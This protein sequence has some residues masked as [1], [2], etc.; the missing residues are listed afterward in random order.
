MV[1]DMFVEQVAWAAAAD[2]DLVIAETFSYAQEALLALDV[3]KQAGLDAVITLAIH[4]H[5]VTRDGWAVGDACRRI[6]DAGATVVGLNCCRGPHTML[7]LLV[8]VRAACD[9]PIAALPV[10]YRTTAAEPTFQSL[11]DPGCDLIPDGR[12]FPTALDPFTCN[13]YEM[14]AFASGRPRPRRDLPRCLLRGGAAPH[15][16]RRGGTRAHAAREPV[17]RRHAPPRVL[18]DR[19]PPE[20]RQPGVRRG[21]VVSL[22]SRLA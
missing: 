1:R 5:P 12:P 4:R 2:V 20:G 11:T 19:R 8:E 13:R 10:P 15:P 9:G 22:D 7:P 16:Q 3:I 18:R 17:Q 21:A 6:E 14:G